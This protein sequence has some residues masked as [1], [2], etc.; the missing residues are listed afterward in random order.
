[1]VTGN[2]DTSTPDPNC[3]NVDC[4]ISHVFRWQDGNLIDLGALPRGNSSDA[5]EINERGEVA[6]LSSN[7]K[8]DPLTGSPEARAVLWTHGKVM[9]LG[10]LGGATSF[11]TGIN[12][13]GL[14]IG[15][16]ANAVPD[17][18]SMFGFGTETRTFVWK[19][20]QMRD[21]GTLGGPDA[22]PWA[23]PNN[24]GQV[25]GS[26]YTSSTVNADTGSP[27]IHPFLW[28]DGTMADLGS[29]GGTL[30]FGEGVNERGEVIGIST[31]AGNI[32]GANGQPIFHPFIWRHGCIRDLG[33]LGGDNGDVSWINDAGQVVGVADLPG[34]ETHDAFLW[35][36]GRMVDLGN[37]GQTSRASAINS[38]GQ[39]VGSSKTND[40]Q[41]HAFLWNKGTPMI[42]L[43]V[44]VPEGADLQLLTDALNINDRG[45]IMGLG[46]PPGIPTDNI[47]FGAH[48]FLLVPCRDESESCRAAGTG[49]IA[50]TS[51]SG[52]E[53]ARSGSRDAREE[54]RPISVERLLNRMPFRHGNHSF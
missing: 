52:A 1:M 39:V 17:P 26:S 12:D 38:R 14:V 4:F 50:V 45:E 43:N 49:R 36:R 10:T 7:G 32:A 3:F 53:L 5:T 54:R 48:V 21:I 42:D 40:G 31:L 9:N 2:A 44:F 28:E 30:A 29:L 47:D 13:S 33:T 18:L 25:S 37:L 46:F 19:N 24:R 27:T 22:A 34:S 20:G 35:E 16:S 51:A 8:I 11:A 23:G 15:A 6:G 41:F